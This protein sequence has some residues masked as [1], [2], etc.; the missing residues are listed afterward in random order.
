MTDQQHAI[1]ISDSIPEVVEVLDSQMSACATPSSTVPTIGDNLSLQLNSNIFDDDDDGVNDKEVPIQVEK[2]QSLINIDDEEE[3]L[4]TPIS[5]LVEKEI[6]NHN[7][8]ND[9]NDRVEENNV[10]KESPTR[11]DLE[12]SIVED[13]IM[14]DDSQ[15]QQEDT[16][17][18]SDEEEEEEEEESVQPS[19]IPDKTISTC[20]VNL[21][22]EGEEEE[23]PSSFSATTE[24]VNLLANKTPTLAITPS[25][26]KAPIRTF[27]KN[28]A[29]ENTSSSSEK[30]STISISFTNVSHNLIDKIQKLLDEEYI[31]HSKKG[32]KRENVTLCSGIIEANPLFATEKI[33]FDANYLK[34]LKI[35][36]EKP[37]I[38][39]KP[40]NS[41]KICYNCLGVGHI[42]R[43]CTLPID[44]DQIELN[45][46]S[47]KSNDSRFYE[48]IDPRHTRSRDRNTA[49]NN[50]L[51]MG[52]MAIKLSERTRRKLTSHELESYKCAT[53]ENK[54]HSKD[55]GKVSDEFLYGG[56]L[57]AD[58]SG[59]KEQL[60]KVFTKLK[61]HKEGGKKRK[62]DQANSA[63][64]DEYIHVN[65]SQNSSKKFKKNKKYKGSNNYSQSQQDR[66]YNN[67]SNSRNNRNNNNY[68]YKSNNRRYQDNDR[69]QDDDRYDKRYNDNNR[70]YHEDEE[71]EYSQRSYSKDRNNNKNKKNSNNKKYYSNNN[72]R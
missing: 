45:K 72:R 28:S 54:V 65:V 2:T 55:I 48:S 21:E 33:N 70:H 8:N 5:A 27:R 29:S 60:N 66:D 51:D 43:D 24:M 38:E 67:N 19:I 52:D 4:I 18:E 37:K 59:R 1:I 71:E 32:R 14:I 3:D 11:Q 64:E 7:N 50:A 44:Y 15:S 69:Y 57:P 30:E 10:E 23:Q 20:T 9:G 49:W 63:S 46:E 12:E 42:I 56:A 53:P 13:V 22:E 39:D 26:E 61:E 40:P 58:Y 41:N 31:N 25:A 6:N 17:F 16:G 68:N 36:V 62:L 34:T 35:D 47:F